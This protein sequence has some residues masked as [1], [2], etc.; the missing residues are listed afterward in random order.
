MQKL[1]I[2]LRRY[3]LADSNETNILDMDTF[4]WRKG[5]ELPD[6]IY[7]SLTVEIG[8]TFLLIGGY[9]PNFGIY[10]RNILEFDPDKERWLERPEKTWQD[11]Y[12]FALLVDRDF[13]KCPSYM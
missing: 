12:R 6:Y 7:N 13:I 1:H 2:F 9:W 5:P 11:Y 10:P 3:L 4:E 8:D